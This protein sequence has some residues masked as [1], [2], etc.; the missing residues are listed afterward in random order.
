[1]KVT[2]EQ[3]EE[4]RERILDVAG[5][6]LREKGF[7]G[8][9]IADIMKAAGLTHGGFYRHFSSKDDLLEQASR[10]VHDSTATNWSRFT[11]GT[12]SAPLQSLLAQYL[13]EYHLD[14]AEQGCMFSALGADASRQNTAIRSVF[15]GGLKS[16]LDVLTKILPGRSRTARRRL[17]ISTFSEMVGAMVLARAVDDR[18]LSKEILHAAALNIL[19]A[20]SLP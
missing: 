20:G 16:L 14:H 10:V 19:A 4:N 13:S 12:L 9:G 6:L 3:C 15:K 8:I 2:R 5:T 11:D 17:A 7:D 1:M 18:E